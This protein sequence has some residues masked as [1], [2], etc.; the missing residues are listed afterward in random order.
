MNWWT[1]FWRLLVPLSLTSHSQEV[2]VPEAVVG[3]SE[4]ATERGRMPESGSVEKAAVTGLVT[5][6]TLDRF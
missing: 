4:K 3:R 5:V 1:G 6:M 2:M